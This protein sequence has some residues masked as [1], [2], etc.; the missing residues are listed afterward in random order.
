MYYGEDDVHLY[1]SDTADYIRKTTVLKNYRAMTEET[2]LRYVERVVID[3]CKQTSP[4]R[5][6]GITK[7]LL[8]R[9]VRD[10]LG[11]MVEEENNK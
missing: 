1:L 9:Y 5:N 4:R 3:I 10:V 8:R 7:D 11:D 2:K 6:Y